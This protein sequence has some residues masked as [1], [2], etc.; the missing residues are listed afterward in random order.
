[1][2]PLKAVK[3]LQELS[4][5]SVVQCL[6]TAFRKLEDINESRAGQV[7]QNLASMVNDL[8]LEND[9]K[10]DQMT[11]LKSY[12]EGLHVS[13]QDKLANDLFKLEDPIVTKYTSQI[14][15][16]KRTTNLDIKYMMMILSRTAS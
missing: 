3:T 10:E 2:A 7:T 1:M 16:D 13:I 11:Q 9:D 6:K 5:N 12:F 15:V 8:K 4:H 14:L